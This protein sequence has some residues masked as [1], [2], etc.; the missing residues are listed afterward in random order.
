MRVK[1]DYLVLIKKGGRRITHTQTHTQTHTHRHTHTHT[2][3]HTY[4]HTHT[5]TNWVN[6]AKLQPL[7]IH[8]HMYLWMEWCKVPMRKL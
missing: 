7:Y 2:Q 1:L 8:P 5:F 6:G 3:R 4:T